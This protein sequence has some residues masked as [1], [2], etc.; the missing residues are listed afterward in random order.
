MSYFYFQ[1]R[2][3]NIILN[4]IYHLP[5]LIKCSHSG[6]ILAFKQARCKQVFPCEFCPLTFMS[7]NASLYIIGINGIKFPQLSLTWL[8]QLTMWWRYVL[9][10]FSD[11]NLISSPLIQS[12]SSKA[13]SRESFVDV[14]I[15]LYSFDV[16]KGILVLYLQ[17]MINNMINN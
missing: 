15:N 6:S 1:H 12:R 8:A 7:F 9:L 4:V 2:K 13:F 17:G 11:L 5:I 3:G 10:S 14:L 16:S